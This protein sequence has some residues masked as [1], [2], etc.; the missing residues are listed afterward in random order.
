MLV[1]YWTFNLPEDAQLAR[2]TMRALRQLGYRTRLRLL[3]NPPP[4]LRA[5]RCRRR[6]GRD[7]RLSRREPFL[8]PLLFCRGWRPRDRV[9]SRSWA[10]S[11]TADGRFVAKAVRLQASAPDRARRHWAAADRRLV[12]QAAW[13]PLVNPGLVYVTGTRVGNYAWSPT[14]G[15]LLDQ[16]WVR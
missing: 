11:A 12:D 1:T 10:R 16:M 8:A 4:S 3:D 9:T 13:V 6:A 7:P 2:I 15:A 14:A 5:D